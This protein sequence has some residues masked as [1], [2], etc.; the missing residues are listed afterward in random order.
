MNTAKL[1]EANLHI[2]RAL[3]SEYPVILN[4]MPPNWF[5]EAGYA[6]HLQI[7]ELV[8]SNTFLIAQQGQTLIG[9]LGWSNHV[10]FNSCYVKFLYVKPEYQ[11]SSVATRLTREVIEIATEAEQRA[12][13]MS[14]PDESPLLATFENMPGAELAG[15]VANFQ[16][17]GVTSR[18]IMLDLAKRSELLGFIDSKLGK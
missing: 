5:A 16:E 15:S 12:V 17:T 7:A 3:P 8:N 14:I 4:S 1:T 6:V 2:G 9:G 13:F 18:V 10:A 11:R